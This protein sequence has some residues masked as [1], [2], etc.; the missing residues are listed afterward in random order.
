MIISFFC[1]AAACPVKKSELACIQTCIRSAV[2]LIEGDGDARTAPKVM[3]VLEANRTFLQ[4]AMTAH[5]RDDLS[6]FTFTYEEEADPEIFFIPY[7]WEVI[8][9]TVTASSIEWE[10][11]KILVFPLLD[12]EDEEEQTPAPTTGFAADVSDVV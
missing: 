11:N 10:T 6:D 8:V 5:I 2:S 1:V 9:C 12:E 4:E 3:Q 7:V